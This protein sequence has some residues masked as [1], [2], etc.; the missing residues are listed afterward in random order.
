MHSIY[1]DHIPNGISW[2]VL[3]Q[4]CPSEHQQGGQSSDGTESERKR[5]QEKE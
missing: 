2:S 1:V 3:V 4:E 5:E